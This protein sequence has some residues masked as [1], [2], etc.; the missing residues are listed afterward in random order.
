MLEE[1]LSI[2]NKNKE[3]Q[4]EVEELKR[5]VEE[6]SNSKTKKKSGKPKQSWLTTIDILGSYTARLILDINNRHNINITDELP[7]IGF[8]DGSYVINEI[9]REKIVR[10]YFVLNNL[11]TDNNSVIIDEAIFNIIKEDNKILGSITSIPNNDRVIRVM[12]AGTNGS[13]ARKLACAIRRLD[14]L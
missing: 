9:D 12:A 7:S 10:K 14:K 2:Y 4:K 13:Y 6:L 8:H 3:L 1:I 5:K 11:I